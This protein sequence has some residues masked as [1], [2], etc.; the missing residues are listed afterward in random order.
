MS[1]ITTRQLALAL[2]IGCPIGAL[3]AASASELLLDAPPGEIGLLVSAWTVSMVLCGIFMIT[4]AG[5]RGQFTGKPSD[6][7][8]S[9]D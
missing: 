6:G 5:A 4:N 2:L 7:S 1:L 8:G 3:L 9:S